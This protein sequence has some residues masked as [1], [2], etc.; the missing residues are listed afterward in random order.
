[1]LGV[2]GVGALAPDDPRRPDDAPRRRSELLLLPHRHDPHR[3]MRLGRPAL[4][5]G[6]P[7]RADRQAGTRR[8]H[9]P[10]RCTSAP[11][12]PSTWS[13]WKCVR[14]MRSSART[15]S[16]RRQRSTAFGSGPASTSTAWC[17]AVATTSASPWP[18][19]HATISQPW[20]R[21]WPPWTPR[22]EGHQG[23]GDARGDRGRTSQKSRRRNASGD[24]EDAQQQRAGPAVRPR[25]RG[26]RCARAGVCDSHDPGDGYARQMRDDRRERQATPA[27]TSAVMTPRIVAGATAGA[28]RR[29]ATTAMRLT[30]PESSTMTGAHTS[31]A[32][33]GTAIES[34]SQPGSHRAS[35]RR[36]PGAR[37]SSPPVARTDSAKPYD[38]PR[39]GSMK[40]SRTTAAQSDAIPARRPPRVSARTP[41]IPVTV[42]RRT[43]GSGRAS[44]RKPRIAS[45]P[46]AGTARARKPAHRAAKSAAT[47]TKATLLPETA[48]R[49]VSPVVLQ[50]SARSGGSREVSPSTSPGSRPRSSGGRTAAARASPPRS[51]AA[52]RCSVDGGP[53]REGG[54]R[55][56]TTA[57]RSRSPGRGAS[58]RPVT[59]TC[60]LGTRCAHPRVGPRTRTGTRVDH[61][62]PRASMRSSLA[63]TMTPSGARTE[64]VDRE[65]P[66][67]RVGGHHQLESG[68]RS[69]S[70]QPGNGAFVQRLLPQGDAE[71]D[72]AAAHD[73][74]AGGTAYVASA[75][76]D[77]KTTRQPQQSQSD[78]RE[79][80]RHETGPEGTEPG[81]CCR[82]QQP[83]VRTSGPVLAHTLTRGAEVGKAG[84]A[85][86]GDLAQLVHGG[87]A[88]V[89][90]TPVDDAL[91]Q[92]RPDAG[93]CLELLEGGAVEVER[94]TAC[95]RCR[96][97]GRTSRRRWPDHPADDDLLAVLE[98]SREVERREV[99][100]TQ[101]ATGRGD[102]V[103]DARPLRE[104]YD[105]RV[106]HLAC[107]IDHDQRRLR[108]GRRAARAQLPRLRRR[109]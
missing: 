20:R 14:T 59:S 23:E 70:C 93:E 86:A 99:H 73:G 47:A 17:G 12:S 105:S 94:S 51:R 43:L 48:T 35:E 88:T 44:T 42:A 65:G 76:G 18:T 67:P 77:G 41:T 7:R 89:S 6:R 49:W 97:G 33:A 69:I 21:P 15:S 55:A 34:A 74:D 66:G 37:T 58:S 38:R 101:R 84:V 100:A 29:F 106:P 64:P 30:L 5:P 85:D 36:H 46:T 4:R 109:R 80:R 57:A 8:A 13:A 19:S 27:P 53:V 28:A 102:R 62:L 107:N 81:G 3:D 63:L 72:G 50:S 87:E 103:D 82:R 91:P 39:P 9:P 11:G 68:D 95:G 24:A 96:A 54:P 108:A 10:T 26:V 75:A 2:V 61:A 1:M 52:T 83:Q 92:R 79:D 98:R 32:A 90:G 56:A 16:R 78:Q 60:W 22:G 45:S 31:C 71:H 40:I 104:A 25:R